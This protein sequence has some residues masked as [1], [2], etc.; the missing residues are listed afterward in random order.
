MKRLWLFSHNR[1]HHIKILHCHQ[2]LNINQIS[3]L[4]V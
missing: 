2:P 3:H 4:P 1:H